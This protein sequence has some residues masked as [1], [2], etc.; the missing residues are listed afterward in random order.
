ME[1]F[2]AKLL[3]VPPFIAIVIWATIFF[4]RWMQSRTIEGR[5]AAI[6]AAQKALDR[7]QH[8]LNIERHLSQSIKDILYDHGRIDGQTA[9]RLAQK[10]AAKIKRSL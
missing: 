6:D 7:Q 4:V 3:V 8:L 5:K 1:L 10:Y 9:T 2:F